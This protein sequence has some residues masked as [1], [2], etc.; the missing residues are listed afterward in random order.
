[1]DPVAVR[2]LLVLGV[3]TVGVCCLYLVPGVARSPYQASQPRPR[4]ERTA[5]PSVSAVQDASAP[6][7]R[8]PRTSPAPD[9][10]ATGTSVPADTAA[11]AAPATATAT[12]APVEPTRTPAPRPQRPP[13]TGA[14]AFDPADPRD[15]EAPEPVATIT[16]AD[17]SPTA[18]TLRWPP[19]ADNV[20]VV[21]Y[22]VV[23][24]GYPVATTPTT[25][26]TVRWFN[27]TRQQ[28]VQVRAV[29]AAGNESP[30]SPTL[31]VVRP[32]PSPTPSPTPTPTAPTPGPSEPPPSAEPTP[33]PTPRPAEPS[34]APQVTPD[35]EEN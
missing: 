34:A 27:D 24:N 6:A 25:S 23:L 33:Q 3:C 22:E 7:S 1:M 31:L 21:E 32:T 10:T 14:T 15:D 2:R 29:D 16:S 20:G 19:A 12:S 26:A 17:V 30:S 4:D 35:D 5:R 18:L 13:R 28:V 8:R 9:A 11:P